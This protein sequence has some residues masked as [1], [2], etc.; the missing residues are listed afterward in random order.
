MKVSG[1]C[2]NKLR[3]TIDLET[4]YEE[5]KKERFNESP[6]LFD[7]EKHLEGDENNH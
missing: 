2:L 4:D 6:E 1:W 7:E 3:K 5:L